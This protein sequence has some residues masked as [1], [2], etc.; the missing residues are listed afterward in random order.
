MPSLSDSLSGFAVGGEP[1]VIRRTTGINWKLLEA[2]LEAPGRE[3]NALK[4]RQGEAVD[5]IARLFPAEYVAWIGGVADGEWRWEHEQAALPEQLETLR[6]AA[7]KA[8]GTFTGATR[9]A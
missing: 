9:T 2:A 1:T 8:I 6:E 7:M 5:L 3:K 4:S